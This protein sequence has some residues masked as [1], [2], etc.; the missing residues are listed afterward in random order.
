M[1]ALALAVGLVIGFL[2]A[3]GPFN[4]PT[5]SCTKDADCGLDTLRCNGEGHCEERCAYPRLWCGDRCAQCCD[6]QACAP[7]G[8]CTAAGT[9]EPTCPGGQRFCVLDA[10]VGTCA[11]CCSN[12]DCANQGVCLDGRCGCRI[13]QKLCNGECISVNFC[14]ADPTGPNDN[15]TPGLTCDGGLCCD[16]I[17]L[18]DDGGSLGCMPWSR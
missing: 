18:A 13:D 8:H 3:C 14:C 11:Q 9:C 2:A 16:Y 1:K 15:C 7:Y 10:G 12:Q 4:P 6:D 5:T 17:G